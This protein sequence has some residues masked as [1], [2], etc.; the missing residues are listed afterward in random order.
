[1][2]GWKSPNGS[3]LAEA[4]SL[5]ETRSRSA[6]NVAVLRILRHKCLK[7]QMPTFLQGLPQRI[8]FGQGLPFGD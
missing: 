2:K 6:K 5:W 8:C 3:R 7:I 1:M 4:Y